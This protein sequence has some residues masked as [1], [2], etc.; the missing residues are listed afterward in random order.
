MNARVSKSIKERNDA[1]F[2]LDR[3][4]IEAYFKK[5]GLKIPESDIVFWA[6][7]YKCIYNIKNAPAELKEQAKTW[8]QTHGMRG[9]IT[10]SYQSN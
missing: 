10:F 2:S 6:S 4:T 5:C 1:L 8:L 7:V 9:E 3:P